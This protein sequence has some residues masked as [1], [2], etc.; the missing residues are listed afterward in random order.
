MTAWERIR[1]ADS[2]PR[3]YELPD[4]IVLDDGTSIIA[5][6]F[7]DLLEKKLVIYRRAVSDTAWTQI[8]IRTEIISLYSTDFHPGIC[9]LPNQDLLVF[10]WNDLDNSTVQLDAYVSQDLGASWALLN[11]GALDAVISTSGSGYTP[12]RIRAAA[13]NDQVLIF[14]RLV[15]NNAAA[16]VREHMIQLAS[17]NLGASFVTGSISSTQ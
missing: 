5:A 3:S 14:A 17:S 12:G 13:N 8:T 15:N 6:Q 16:A 2:G 11:G 7:N 1:W 4:L 9:Q 10:A